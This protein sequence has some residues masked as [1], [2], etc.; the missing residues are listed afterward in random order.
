MWFSKNKCADGATRTQTSQLGNHMSNMSRLRGKQT[1]YRRMHTCADFHG[2]IVDV[3]P[4]TGRVG[5]YRNYSHHSAMETF[6][7]TPISAFKPW[8]VTVHFLPWTYK[9]G[10]YRRTP[11]H[12]LIRPV[13]R[14]IVKRLQNTRRS[15][16]KREHRVA[17]FRGFTLDEV[18]PGRKS[19]TNGAIV[20]SVRERDARKG[21]FQ[22]SRSMLLARSPRFK[23]ILTDWS[24]FVCVQTACV[25]HRVPQTA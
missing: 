25:V 20:I 23:M 9:F 1:E 24:R 13:H 21:L 4:G 18:C 11:W 6:A 16:L 12:R 7:Q 10:K 22:I 3:S 14:S 15:A 19:K 2:S 17:K 5:Q 8:W